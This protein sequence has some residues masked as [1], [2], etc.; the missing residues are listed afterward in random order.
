MKGKLEIR[1]YVERSVLI[2]EMKKVDFLINFENNSNVQ[3]PSKL[4]DYAIVNRPI[5]NVNTSI[6]DKGK[7]KAFLQRDYSDS[8][9]ISNLEDYHI[10]NVVSKIIKLKSEICVE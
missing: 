6:I 8:Y 5:L 2:E 4:I 9:R 3:S 10:R 1:E 7:I